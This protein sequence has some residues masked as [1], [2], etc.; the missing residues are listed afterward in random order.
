MGSAVVRELSA[1]GHDVLGVARRSP[2]DQPTASVAWREADVSTGDLVPVVT[3]ADAVVHL[4]WRFQPPVDPRSPGP[5]TRPGPGASSTRSSPRGCRRWCASPRSRPTPRRG[6]T[7]PS[8]SA[9]RPTARRRRRTAG[10][11]RTSSARVPTCA[12]YD[13]V[14]HSCS[15]G[16][17]R[18][19]NGASSADRSPGRSSSTPSAYPSCP[20]RA[21][22]G[23]RRSTAAT[24]QRPWWLPSSG[25]SAVR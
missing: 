25:P 5:P 7:T 15:S 11:R 3:G 10:R 24:S 6:T 16:R 8:T 20:C 17:R 9:G 18:A 14:P 1:A 19:S 2:V 23:S 22:C 21:G 13:C 12:S 4:A